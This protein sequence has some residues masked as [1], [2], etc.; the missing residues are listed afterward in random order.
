MSRPPKR[1]AD[2]TNCRDPGNG[3]AWLESGSISP[4]GSCSRSVSGGTTK[5]R[6]NRFLDVA[7]G[8]VTVRLSKPYQLLTRCLP[9]P[10]WV[11][12]KN[13]DVADFIGAPDTIRTCDLCLRE[14]SGQPTP[15]AE[16]SPCRRSAHVLLV[17]ARVGV[18][19][20][21][22]KSAA[23]PKGCGLLWKDIDKSAHH[24]RLSRPATQ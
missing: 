3:N 8:W 4:V 5:P 15:P 6:R 24:S 21:L 9:K 2:G 14:G 19:F 10:I 17:T 1:H 16:E 20:I 18:A 22:R 23:H 7:S 13:R 12:V 11:I